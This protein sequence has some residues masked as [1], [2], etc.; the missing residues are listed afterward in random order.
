MIKSVINVDLPRVPSDPQ[1]LLLS[2][3]CFLAYLDR[4]SQFLWHLQ[5]SQG[6]PALF[7][8][9]VQQHVGRRCG[10]IRGCHSSLSSESRFHVLPAGLRH[11]RVVELVPSPFRHI[12]HVCIVVSTER[13]PAMHHD[14]VEV[15]PQR[16]TCRLR[17]LAVAAGVEGT[18]PFHPLWVALVHPGR[19]VCDGHA[20]LPLRIAAEIGGGIEHLGEG[21]SVCDLDT[22][23]RLVVEV[24]TL[25]LDCEDVRKVGELQPLVSIHHHLLCS[26][27]SRI[28]V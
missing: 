11:H 6:L 3:Q 1:L 19:I 4:L 25:E 16:V 18:L 28:G 21:D 7:P 9:P 2:L 24:E 23:H 17:G 8:P 12:L 10:Q 26:S 27:I 22:P 5:L 20:S 14:A 13:A 15:V